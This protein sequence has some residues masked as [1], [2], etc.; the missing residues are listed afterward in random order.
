MVFI[1]NSYSDFK[2]YKNGKKEEKDLCCLYMYFLIYFIWLVKKKIKHKWYNFHNECYTVTK[3]CNAG[4]TPISIRAPFL[5]PSF[6][7]NAKHTVRYRMALLGGLR[8]ACGTLSAGT[9]VCSGQALFC[10]KTAGRLCRQ[11]MPV[12]HGGQSAGGAAAP[13]WGWDRAG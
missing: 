5:F 9:S 12:S 7:F 1:I 6:C 2:E 4:W 13:G 3:R 11:L 10:Q 8:A